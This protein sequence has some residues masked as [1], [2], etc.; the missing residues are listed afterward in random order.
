MIGSNV[1]AINLSRGSIVAATVGFMP[2]N[3]GDTS[4]RGE[5]GYRVYRA[6]R[7]ELAERRCANLVVEFDNCPNGVNIT[8]RQKPS[9]P[10]YSVMM[11]T[12]SNIYDH[13]K[14]EDVDF[15]RKRLFD[16]TEERYIIQLF[17]MLERNMKEANRYGRI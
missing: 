10:E 11:T 1:M 9:E 8:F 12:F 5:V 13:S 15:S 16:I 7:T 2:S 17:G 3:R 14:L 4:F 6:C